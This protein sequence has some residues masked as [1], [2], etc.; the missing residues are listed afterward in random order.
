ME[1]RSVLLPEYVCRRCP[2]VLPLQQ[3]YRTIRLTHGNA[4]QAHSDLDTGDDIECLQGP[5]VYNPIVGT[6]GQPKAKH[7][8]EDHKTSEGLHSNLSFSESV[9]IPV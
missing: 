2:L 4:E 1:E 3:E 6:P 9:Y 7:V 5:C 8:F